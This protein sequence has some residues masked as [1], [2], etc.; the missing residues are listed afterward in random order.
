MRKTSFEA[1]AEIRIFPCYLSYSLQFCV[2][3]YTKYLIYT[4]KMTIFYEKTCVCKK[5]V[6]LLQPQKHRALFIVL[7]Q[8]RQG[9]Y[10]SN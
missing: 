6:V 7:S 2:Q 9:F 3:N 4:K 10:S 8:K 5:F 1:S